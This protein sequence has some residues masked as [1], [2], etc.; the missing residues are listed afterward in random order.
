MEWTFWSLRRSTESKCYLN[1][2]SY[3]LDWQT[4]VGTCLDRNVIKACSSSNQLTNH[5]YSFHHREFPPISILVST[6]WFV[7]IVHCPDLVFLTV[8]CSFHVCRD[9][10]QNFAQ[11]K[12]MRIVWMNHE[13]AW[14]WCLA[15]AWWF[16]DFSVRWIIKQMKSHSRLKRLSY[17]LSLSW[18]HNCFHVQLLTVVY[19]GS[20][21]RRQFA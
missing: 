16:E 4:T 9:F 5:F 14:R 11:L 20:G 18:S 15:N 2:L 12:N 19:L 17:P 7:K 3:G 8:F 6:F 13:S 21:G 1:I 10:R